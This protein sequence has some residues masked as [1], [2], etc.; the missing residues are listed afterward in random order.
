MKFFDYDINKLG[1][2]CM[3]FPFEDG[4]INIEKTKQLIDRFMEAGFN[5]FD[6]AWAYD[7]SETALREALVERYPRESYV[8]TTK[9]CPWSHC[10]STEDLYKQF[11]E[12]LEA[13]GL[14]YVDFVLVHNTGSFRTVAAEKY[15]AWG[16]VNEIKA[17]GRAKHI[18]FSTHDTPEGVEKYIREHPGA[19]MILMQLNYYDWD[20]PTYRVKEVY[21]TIRK[22]DIPITCMGPIKG[23]L[24]LDIPQAAK[25]AFDAVTPGLSP[26][27]WALR[28][29]ASQPGVMAVLSGMGEMNQMEENIAALKDFEG[30][31]S[32]ELAA[33]DKAAKA[34]FEQGRVQCTSCEYCLKVCPFTVDIPGAMTAL[35]Y[36]DST[37]DGE[38]AAEQVGSHAFF[39]GRQMVMACSHC[40]ACERVCP[41]SI[42]IRKHLDRVITEVLPHHNM[43]KMARMR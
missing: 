19:E 1:F 41:Q 36:F 10:S 29:A 25:D 7:G 30:L 12:S 27:T 8:I 37:N 32:D 22:H 35:N 11:D 43:S 15:D 34:L 21:E 31:S 16:V 24:L 20:N 42:E 40:G 33:V 18:G 38:G 28:F 13:M 9:I 4:K 2:G 23:G 14:D 6:T 5:Y 26:A 3:R 17:S 39:A